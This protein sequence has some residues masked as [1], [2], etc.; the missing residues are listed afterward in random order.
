[1]IKVFVNNIE[2][3]LVEYSL[4]INEQLNERATCQFNI[5]SDFYRSVEKSMPIEIL[6]VNDNDEVLD[7]LFVGFVDSATHKDYYNQNVRIY[8][9]KGKDLHYL[10]DKRVWVRGFV[11]ETCG[12]IVKK[13]VDETLS[14]EGITYTADSVQEGYNVPAISFSY[15]KCSEILNQL[16]ELAGY[17]WFV[18]YNGV[19]H[20][21]SAGINGEAPLVTDSVVKENSLVIS[22]KNS[23][24]RRR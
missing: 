15:K 22:N 1:M 21:K 19:L 4:S 17:V 2:F 8:T 12:A 23:Q 10:I 20:F 6:D 13:M 7:V 11:N 18:D 5:K 3:P 14:H 9:V 16:S 24:Y